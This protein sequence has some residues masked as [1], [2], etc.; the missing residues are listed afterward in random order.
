MRKTKI[1]CTIGPASETSEMLEK[2]MKAGMNTAR[3]NFSHGTHE[4]HLVKIARIKELREKLGLPVAIMLDTKGP[5]YRTGLFEGGFA[6]VKEGDTFTFTSEK[7]VGDSRHCTVSYADLAKDLQVGDTVLVCNG[8]LIFKVTAIEGNNVV[9]EVVAGGRI[10]DHKSMA[11]PDRVLSQP[12]LSEQDK[13]D[14]LFGIENDVDFVAAS[15]VSSRADIAS[16]RSFLDENGGKS[17]QIIAKIENRSGVDCVDEILDIADG[18]MVGRGD[19]GV[20][21]PYEEVPDIQKHLIQSC[22]KR[23]KVVITATEMLESMIH[24]PRP[25]RAEVSDVANAVYDYSGVIMLS[26]ESAAGDYPEEAVKTMA[27][28]AE[29]TEGR[30]DYE[31]QFRENDFPAASNEEAIARAAC[32]LAYD[33][34]TKAIAVT[35]MSGETVHKVAK[36]RVGL[37]VAGVTADEKVYRQLS[38]SWGVVPMLA[39]KSSTSEKMM[40][41]GLKACASGLKLKKGDLVVVT[42]GKKPGKAGGSNRLMLEDVK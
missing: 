39:E 33:T 26:G 1:I 10:A 37:P 35:T 28:I 13:K 14:L 42:T 5:E 9:T 40:E 27:K 22:L 12:F 20:E 7:V 29:Y 25:T 41:G 8:L 30:I 11:F 19:L 23:A 18:V 36:F 2:L 15:F 6:E 24:N 3:L 21:I 34:G 38:L 16:M 32:S 17:I 31:K 4:E